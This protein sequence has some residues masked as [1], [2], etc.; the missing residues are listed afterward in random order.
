MRGKEPLTSPGL[1]RLALGNFWIAILY[2]V[3]YIFLS[4][5]LD[6]LKYF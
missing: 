3:L 5:F 2:V 1:I 6:R 4:I